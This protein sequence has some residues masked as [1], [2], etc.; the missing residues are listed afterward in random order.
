MNQWYFIFLFFLMP[1]QL[2]AQQYIPS[3]EAS[4]KF[5]AHIEVH[6]VDELNKLLKRSEQLFDDGKLV[7][8]KDTAVA[9]VLHGR[10]ASSLFSENYK[11][12]KSMV[13]LAARLSAFDVV[14]IKVC[15]TWMGGKGLDESQLP[16]FIGTVPL[17][18][19]EERRLLNEEAYVYF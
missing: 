5:L 10:E 8:G 17:G 9:F 13:D 2:S 14:D 19:A 4:P 1:L 18:P 16:P 7:P 6:T 12:N 3:D 15:K 11:N